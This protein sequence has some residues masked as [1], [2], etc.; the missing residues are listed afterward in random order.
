[1]V[2]IWCL[3]NWIEFLG[4]E[5]KKRKKKDAKLEQPIKNDAKL[6]QPM[7]NNGVKK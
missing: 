5:G 3:Y 7:E 6:K 2:F 4:I 1:M